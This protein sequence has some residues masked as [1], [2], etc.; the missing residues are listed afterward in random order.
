MKPINEQCALAIEKPY[1][2]S[3]LWGYGCKTEKNIKRMCVN[4]QKKANLFTPDKN[5]Q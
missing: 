4:C 5:E 3:C 2:F 1:L